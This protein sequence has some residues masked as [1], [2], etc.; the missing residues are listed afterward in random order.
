MSNIS[1][2]IP[3]HNREPYLSEAISSVAHQTAPPAELIIVDDLGRHETVDCIDSLRSSAPFPILYL[4]NSQR[5]GAP[6][7]RNIGAWAASSDYLAFL[8]D[9]DRWH[10]HFI[11][12]LLRRLDGSTADFA[13]AWCR[14]FW[15]DGVK[16][17]MAMP[18]NVNL[19]WALRENPGFS[20]QNFVIRREAFAQVGGF[21]PEAP[22]KHDWELLVRLLAGGYSYVV[23]DQRLVDIRIHDGPRV[24]TRRGTEISREFDGKRYFYRKHRAHMS[25]GTRLSWYYTFGRLY[26]R[27][28]SRPRLLR[29][30]LSPVVRLLRQARKLR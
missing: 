2:V 8:D 21:D 7:S 18:E 30:A 6:T 1:V 14:K 22:M 26:V 11:D 24:S 20:G 13:I 16:D 3:T 9:D 15:D 4:R 10:S 5:D 29:W 12:L 17:S 28:A 23:V 19:D 25:F 27:D